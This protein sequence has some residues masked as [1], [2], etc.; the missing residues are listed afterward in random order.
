MNNKGK[1]PTYEELISKKRTCPLV[2]H[3]NKE[4]VTKNTPDIESLREHGVPSEKIEELLNVQNKQNKKFIEEKR[5]NFVFALKNEKLNKETRIDDLTKLHNRKHFD[6][7]I[8]KQFDRAK[9]YKESTFSFLLID[10]D[11]FKVVNDIL[12]H[13]AG[14][15]IL[16]KFADILMNEKECKLRDSDVLTRY[17]GEEFGIILPET[18]NGHAMQAAERVRASME[19]FLKPELHRIAK[20][21][22][23]EDEIP[24]LLGTI[25]IG[26]ASYYGEKEGQETVSNLIEQADKGL[27]AAKQGGRNQVI[28]GVEY[29]KKLKKKQT[30]YK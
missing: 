27:Y 30:S 23:K 12:G 8:K 9:R 7:E 25:S 21:Q 4:D 18:S 17:G 28:D 13:Q 11:K 14:D 22:N 26:V 2:E 6:E 10:I 19:K 20:E 15:T 1:Q 5:D 24:K 29:N 3:I 16:K